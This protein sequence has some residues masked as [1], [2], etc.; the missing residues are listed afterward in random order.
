M[1]LQNYM[2]RRVVEDWPQVDTVQEDGE[3]YGLQ[4][5]S[6]NLSSRPWPWT[7]NPL[8]CRPKLWI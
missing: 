4:D 2:R 6:D 3:G 8:L 7:C 5:V 1:L